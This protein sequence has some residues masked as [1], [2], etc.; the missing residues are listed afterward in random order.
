MDIKLTDNSEEVKAALEA[1]KGV[2]QN[3][4]AQTAWNKE[5]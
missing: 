2:N 3:G 5:L 1:V 4:R